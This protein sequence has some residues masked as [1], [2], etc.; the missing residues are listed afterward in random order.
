MLGGSAHNSADRLLLT[1]VGVSQLWFSA[2][3]AER[4]LVTAVG[5]PQLEHACMAACFLGKVAG[6]RDRHTPRAAAAMPSSRESAGSVWQRCALPAASC[7]RCF[8][9][10]ADCLHRS[11]ARRLSRALGGSTTCRWAWSLTTVSSCCTAS[12]ACHSA[13][14]WTPGMTQ[15]I[16]QCMVSW[17]AAAAAAARPS[18]GPNCTERKKLKRAQAWPGA[19][20]ILFSEAALKGAHFVQLCA[21]RGIPLLFLQASW[22]L[23]L[24]PKALAGPVVLCVGSG[25]AGLGRCWVGLPGLLAGTAWPCT[26]PACSAAAPSRPRSLHLTPPDDAFS[27]RD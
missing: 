9:A 12:G 2:Y 4:L 1:A 6:L 26:C 11:T 8:T 5:V 22:A 16:R 20:G 17:G 3:S 25:A 27:L 18:S 10:D 15:S 24:G 13:S 14:T 23:A 7:L 19:A 21:Q